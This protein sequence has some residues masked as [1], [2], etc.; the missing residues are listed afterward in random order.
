ME[1]PNGIYRRVTFCCAAAAAITRPRES[2]LKD[3]IA[4]KRDLRVKQDW[5]GVLFPS[6]NYL[7]QHL[8]RFPKRVHRIELGAPRSWIIEAT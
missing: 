8:Y 4:T 7:P 6:D 2:A 3:T 5:N 1:S